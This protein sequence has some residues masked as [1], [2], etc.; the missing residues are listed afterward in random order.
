MLANEPLG[1]LTHEALGGPVHDAQCLVRVEGEDRHVDLF[2]HLAQ[3][4]GRF[5]RTQPLVSEEFLELI[6]LKI[7]E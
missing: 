6:D 1:A 7:G 3:R 4:F 5:D 2:Q